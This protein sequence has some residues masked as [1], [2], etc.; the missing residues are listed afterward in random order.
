MPKKPKTLIEAAMQKVAVDSRGYSLFLR[1]DDPAR[2][3]PPLP[4]SS[5]YKTYFKL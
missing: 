4:K 2:Q 5:Y 3:L 1:E